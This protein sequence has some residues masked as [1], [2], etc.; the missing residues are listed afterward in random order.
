MKTTY[1]QSLIGHDFV[2][3][4]LLLFYYFFFNTKVTVSMKELL[5]SFAF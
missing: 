5:L 3:F 4:L 2:L 1:N